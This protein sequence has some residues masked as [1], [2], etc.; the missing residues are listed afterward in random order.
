[1][2][3]QVLFKIDKGLKERLVKKLKR[4]GITVSAFVRAIFSAYA[5]GDLEIH[6]AL[7]RPLVFQT[8]K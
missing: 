3:T 7:K 5:N 6:I 1:M 8:K 2:T 4:K